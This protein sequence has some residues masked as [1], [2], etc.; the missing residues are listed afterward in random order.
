MELNALKEWYKQACETAKWYNDTDVQF[1]IRDKESKKKD[2]EESITRADRILKNYQELLDK[3]DYLLEVIRDR[4][5]EFEG[6]S[7]EKEGK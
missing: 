2:Y 3:R 5:P 4:D 7:D 6:I 1:A